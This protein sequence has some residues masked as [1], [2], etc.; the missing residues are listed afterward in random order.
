VIE[1]IMNEVIKV[2]LV[3]DHAVVREGIRAV[4][5]NFTD[6]AVVG[7]AADAQEAIGLAKTLR[8][9]VVICDLRMPGMAVT[10]AVRQ[11]RAQQPQLQVVIFSSF[12]EGHQIQAV[13]DAGAI[14]YLTKDARAEELHQTVLAAHL[15]LPCV[16][17]SVRE[18]LRNTQSMPEAQAVMRLAPRERDVLRGIALAQSNKEIARILGLT[19]GTVKAYVSGIFNKLSVRDRT[20]AA[21]IAMR[22]GLTDS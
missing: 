5:E 12:A 22:V 16:N 19:E 6:V 20:E 1:K 21:L 15:G 13:L 7:E 10:D 4:L 9:Y 8:P 17:A 11:L 18:I 3:D 14:G 2:L